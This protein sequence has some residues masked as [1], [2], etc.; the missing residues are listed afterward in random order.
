MDAQVRVDSRC[1][2]HGSGMLMLSS[3]SRD[4]PPLSLVLTINSSS[5]DELSQAPRDQKYIFSESAQ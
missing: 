2:S 3:S 4:L 5:F 1:Y